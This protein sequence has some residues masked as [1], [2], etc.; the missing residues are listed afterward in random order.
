VD[1]PVASNA[2]LHWQNPALVSKDSHRQ[3]NNLFNSFDLRLKENKSQ[4]LSFVIAI[5]ISPYCSAP[6]VS[7]EVY[8]QQESGQWA[9]L[10]CL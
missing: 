6:K 5:N 9:S 1:E 2:I 8:I 4:I 3:T 7:H 10:L